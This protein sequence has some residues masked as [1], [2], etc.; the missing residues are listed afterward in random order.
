MSTVPNL[1]PA[2]MQHFFPGCKVLGQSRCGNQK[3]FFP[4]EINGHLCSAKFILADPDFVNQLDEQQREEVKQSIITRANRE[5]EAIRNCNSRYLIGIGPVPAACLDFKGHTIFYYTE[6]YINGVDLKEI[7]DKNIVPEFKD[8]VELGTH[9]SD[10]IN[11]LSN[12]NKVHRD[13]KPANIMKRSETGNYVLLDLGIVFDSDDHTLTMQQN[14][15]LGTKAYFSP[16][17]TDFKNRKDMDFRSDLFCLG[18]VM[19]QYLTGKHPFWTNVG[20]R[21]DELINN[22]LFVDPQPPASIRQDIPNSLSDLIMRLIEKQPHSRYRRIR[23]LLNDL[24]KVEV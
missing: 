22:I 3:L 10:A 7:I 19:Y 12:N 21:E 18:T 11:A 4:L 1:N 17:H 20:M 16:E 13:I 8:V 2:D 23:D 5:V 6:E 24:S 14:Y 9:I 15:V